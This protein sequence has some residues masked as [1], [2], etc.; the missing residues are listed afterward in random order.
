MTDRPQ[1]EPGLFNDPTRDIRLPHLP[2][3]P[4]PVLRPEWT[5]EQPAAPA[6]GPAAAPDFTVP[7]PELSSVASEAPARPTGRPD[8]ESPSEEQPTDQLA[9]GVARP[10]ERTLAFSSPEMGRR[11]V[12]P[13]KV[14]ASRRWPWVVLVLL[15]LL[16]IAG[17]AIALVLILRGG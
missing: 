11:P 12:G 1:P 7:P 8:A 10:R 14:A 13:V 5:V 2:D 3:R 9:H 4:A 15:P 17:A 16:V 6:D